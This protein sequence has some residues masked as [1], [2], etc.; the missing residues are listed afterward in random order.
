MRAKLLTL[1]KYFVGWPLSAVALFFI[2]KTILPEWRKIEQ[3][4][5]TVN[6]WLLLIAIF[7]FV[8]YYMLRCFVW[9]IILRAYN[10]SLPFK[11]TSFLWAISEVNRYIPGNIWSF[12]GRTMLFARKEVAKKDIASALLVEAQFILLGVSGVSLL[13][14]TFLIDQFFPTF[15]YRDLV[16]FFLYTLVFLLGVLYV[17][18]SEILLLIGKQP[19]GY[20]KHLLP[21]FTSGVQFRL[22]VASV[23][24]FFFFGL[25]YYFAIIS[26]FFLTPQLIFSFV[27][28]FVFSL[29]IGYASLI[30]P[31]GLGVREGVITL[32]LA[33][34]M[35][36]S[37]AGF[38]AIFARIILVIS[39]MLFIFFTFL[40]EKTRTD[41]MHR[42]ERYIAEHKHEALLIALT[43]LYFLYF[44]TVSLLRHDNFYTGRFDLGNMAQTVWNTGEGRL[45][46]LTN[47]DGTET[48]SRL[49]FHADFIL[50]LF[51]PLYAIWS[52][53]KLLL[54]IQTAIVSF[55]GVIVYMISK[56][57]LRSK[58]LSLLFAFLFFINP[59]VERATIFD[60]HAVVLATTFL[61]GAV[62]F[63]RNGKFGWFLTLSLLA[64]I[65]KEQVWFIVG[66]F[67]ILA[68]VRYKQWLFGIV[69]FAVSLGMFYFLIWHAIP[70]VSGSAYFALSYY[71]DGGDN[72]SALLANT[73]LTPEKTFVKIT[74]QARVDYYKQLF[75]PLAYLPLASPFY[76]VFALPD[77]FINVLSDKPHLH[78]IY[79]QYTAVITP[80]LFLAAIFGL[81]HIRQQYPLIPTN[82]YIGVL[83]VTGLYTA[84]LYGPLP[85]AKEPNLD[86]FVR[87]IPNRQAVQSYLVTIPE[88]ASV[89]ASNNLG[90]HLTNRQHLFTIPIG[91]EQ[92]D[93]IVFLLNDKG[94]QPSLSAQKEMA[95]EL[96]VNPLY[97]VVYEEGDFVMFRKIRE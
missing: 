50:I 18:Q 93:Y 63:M 71:E 73:I 81:K 44:S 11:E 64:A 32:A 28:V 26:V 20:L 41:A 10:Y 45:F 90:A 80:F 13:G 65:T 70:N 31:T 59:S 19:K 88:K 60:F 9:Q 29:L 49:A 74:D 76:L 46:E 61:L 5:S 30:T 83:L 54:L 47:P 97:E 72:P 43:L 39:E 40:W 96:K 21:G 22:L 35:D 51:A 2:I 68:A 91:M 79:Y 14:T 66:L 48:L 89:A 42:L 77:L 38:A 53:P 34:V 36:I 6:I 69:L 78:Q 94:A 23:A 85:G 4:F 24:A 95:E 1:L 75:L 57:V 67:G 16:V 3:S 52:N 27:G 87:Q 56:S 33:K 55:G 86:M 12:L 82:F 15:P 8:A 58:S 37:S 25:G 7:C 84:Y 92:A 17:F 62:Y